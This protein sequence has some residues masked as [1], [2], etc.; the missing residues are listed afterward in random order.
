MGLAGLINAALVV[1][2]VS[3]TFVPYAETAPS[4]VTCLGCEAPDVQ[5]ALTR[6]AKR[7][8]D[9]ILPMVEGSRMIILGLTSAN[10]LLVAAAAWKSR[11]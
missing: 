1:V 2:A 5:W 11:R 4:G 9:E 3:P 7:G 10:V 6:A 8:R